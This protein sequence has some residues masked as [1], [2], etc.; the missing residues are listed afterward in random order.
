MIKNY[1]VTALRSLRKYRSYAAVNLIGLAAGL[2]AVIIIY[3]FIS[4][5]LKYDRFHDNINRI[6]RIASFLDMAGDHSV[7]GPLSHG[8]APPMLAGEIPEIASVTRVD[9][10]SSAEIKYNENSYHN[11][12]FLRVDAEFLDIFSFRISKGNRFDPLANPGTT[13]ITDELA[14]KI[15]GSDDPLGETLV[16]EGMYYTI[17]AVVE[18]IPVHSHIKFDLLVTFSSLPNEE[19]FVNNR[20]FGF[21]SYFMLEEGAEH[22]TAL[23]KSAEVL[24]DYYEKVLEGSGLSVTPFFQPMSKVYLHSENLNYD[25]EKMGNISNIYIFSL[26]ALFILIIAIV[27]YINLSTA[28]AETRS[29][30]VAV[31]KISGST[32][33]DLVKQFIIE[34]VVTTFIAMI[35]SV[36]AAE[37]LLPS[38]SN[39]VNRNLS[40]AFGDP[41]IWLF[42]IITTLVVG[43]AAGSWPAF[44]IAR[45]QPLSILSKSKGLLKGGVLKIILVVFQFS[46][47]IFL[48]TSVTILF[49]QIKYMQTKAPGFKKENIIVLYNLTPEIRNSYEAV[50]DELLKHSSVLSISASNG[51]PG[52]NTNIQNSY[53]AGG[54]S[55]DAVLMHEIRVIDGYIETFEIPI[56]EGRGFSREIQPEIILNQEAVRALGLEDPIGKEIYIWEDRG[57]VIGVVNDYHFQTLHEPIKPI[58]HTRTHLYL[59]Y[60]SVRVAPG[61]TNQTLNL[62]G[63]T[64]GKFDPDYILSYFFMDEELASLYEDEEQNSMLVGYAAVLSIIVSLMGIY[65][66]T[67]FAI[68]RRTKEIGIRKALGASAGSILFMLYRDLGQWVL[69]SNVIG[70]FFAWY[71]MRNW[72]ENFAYRTDMS[73][74]MFVVSGGA[75]IVIALATVT[76]LAVKATRSNPVDALRYE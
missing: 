63:K 21:Y 36:S 11:I 73:P 68:I 33:S 1:I 55:E 57:E 50:R 40:I 43:L 58:A 19:Q 60:L 59:Q 74:W 14:G 32:K 25:I 27:N 37:M 12:R 44:Y 7:T 71:V 28:R 23:E 18:D 62:I 20:G 76:G 2:A 46:I 15:F 54:N 9:P 72:L 56:L 61:T 22:E 29:R 53:P 31:R 39:L 42:L 35:I 48:I 5:E 13:V 70:W 47:A 30:E 4:H 38:F 45:F 24:N 26:L 16:I 52:R 65:A 64:I 69:V 51:L 10:T 6:Y 75:A 3:S 34:S 17:T 67:S 41:G 66:L 8:S 49:S